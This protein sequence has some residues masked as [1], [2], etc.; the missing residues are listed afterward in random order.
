M[1][2]LDLIEIGRQRRQAVDE[3]E[4]AIKIIARLVSIRHT[5]RPPRPAGARRKDRLP[6]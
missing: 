6:Y 3:V 4:Q 1:N 2:I 5:D